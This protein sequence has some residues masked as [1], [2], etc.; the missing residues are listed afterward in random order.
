MDPR[1]LQ[2]QPEST[3]GHKPYE[4]RHDV[5]SP[6]TGEPAEEQEPGRRAAA[7]PCVCPTPTEREQK[8]PSED[9]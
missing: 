6:D 4:F 9:T 1:R 5:P 7:E 2:E 8:A 3:I